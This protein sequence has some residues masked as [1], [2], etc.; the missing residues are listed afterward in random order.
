MKKL[1]IFLMCAAAVSAA[2]W[3][4]EGVLYLNSSPNAVMH[5]VPVHA[6]TIGEGFWYAR[7]KAN[8]ERS[9][10]TMLQLLEANGVVDNFR[11]LSGRKNAPLRGPIYT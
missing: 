7:R 2:D 6:V 11:R 4:D 5:P 9:I 8:V 10:P 3:R 1:A